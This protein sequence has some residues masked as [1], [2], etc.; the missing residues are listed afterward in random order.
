VFVTNTEL[1]PVMSYL[2]NDESFHGG[3]STKK[4]NSTT[5]EED[6]VIKLHKSMPYI[7]Y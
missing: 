2:R 5:A 7:G 4:H 3:G 1:L 6:V